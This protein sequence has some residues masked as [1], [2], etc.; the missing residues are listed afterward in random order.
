MEAR[1]VALELW[2][3]VPTAFLEKVPKSKAGWK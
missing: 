2:E 3:K 1:W